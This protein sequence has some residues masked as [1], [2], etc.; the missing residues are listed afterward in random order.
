MPISYVSHEFFNRTK[1]DCLFSFEFYTVKGIWC[2][3]SK[4]HSVCSTRI[5]EVSIKL[6]CLLTVKLSNQQG[7]GDVL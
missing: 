6:D 3:K 5:V 7:E 2:E 1:I 4:D